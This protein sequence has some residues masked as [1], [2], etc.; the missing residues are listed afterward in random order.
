MQTGNRQK[1]NMLLKQLAEMVI[2]REELLEAGHDADVSAKTDPPEPDSTTPNASPQKVSTQKR[3]RSASHRKIC[4]YFAIYYC[5]H[6]VAHE[7]MYSVVAS[8]IAM[9]MDIYA[10]YRKNI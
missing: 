7:F 2:T 5:K 1:L 9:Y 8:Y 4:L 3:K 6:L 10:L